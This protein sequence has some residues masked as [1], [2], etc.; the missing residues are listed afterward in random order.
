[1]SMS[2]TAQELHDQ[3]ENNRETII[4]DVR[5]TSAYLEWHIDHQNANLINIQTSKLKASGPE[6]FTEIPRDKEIVCVCAHGNASEEAAD[7][8]NEHGYHAVSLRNGMSAWSEFYY[9]TSV[10]ST[11]DFELIQVIR[12]AKGCLSYVLVSGDD[13]IVVDPGRHTDIYMDIAAK[14]S[15]QIREV[16]DT[17]CHAD[18]ISGGSALAS[19]V[20][21]NYWIAAS[22]MGEGRINFHSLEDGLRIPFGTSKLDVIAIPTP[23]H[24]PGST[25]FLV[26]DQYLLSGDT[27][28]VSG[29]GRPDLGG[30]AREWA[31]LLYDT[32]RTKL[33]QIDDQV[34]ILPAHYSGSDEVT[35]Q[36]YVG[37]RLGEI[38]ATNHLLQG[39]SEDEFTD[40]VAGNLGLTPPNYTTIVHVNRGE[41][42][43]SDEE[44][45]EL[46][47]GP[48]RCAVK[49]LVG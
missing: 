5:A 29:L 22:E 27:V 48:N 42:F 49:H 26:N 4:L 19:R 16:L 12:P 24:T 38:R 44:A 20:G 1:M 47:I 32:V 14:H 31:A 34:L 9:P 7:I 28:F 11:D 23:G 45:T 13:A 39:V 18:H 30:K 6:V 40:S 3:M 46:E 33:N 41:L 25:S 35:Q 36:G 8:L 17:H 2:I 21:A 10:V 15:V 43:P 37:A